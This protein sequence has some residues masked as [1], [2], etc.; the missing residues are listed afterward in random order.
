M[1]IKKEKLADTKNVEKELKALN[2]SLA[3]LNIY[4]EKEIISRLKEVNNELWNIE[5]D[6]RNCEKLKKFDKYFVELARSV[7]I[8]NDER[9]S[10]KRLI[11][12]KCSSELIEEK[13][14]TKFN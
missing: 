12:L 8:K 5:D 9:A 1:E 6:I 2:G 14:Y 10:I 7:Y 13:S 3:E 4:I 11:N